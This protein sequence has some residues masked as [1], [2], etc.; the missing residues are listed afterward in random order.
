MQESRSGGVIPDQVDWKLPPCGEEQI[1]RS[2]TDDLIRE[3]ELAVPDV[4]CCRRIEHEQKSR[5]SRLKT[6]DRSEQRETPSCR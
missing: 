2:V 5:R 6:G 1:E 3:R 4:S